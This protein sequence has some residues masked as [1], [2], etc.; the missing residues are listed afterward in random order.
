MVSITPVSLE[1][2]RVE[3]IAE[4][5]AIPNESAQTVK[6]VASVLPSRL[7]PKASS[8]NAS[9]A[10]RA[11]PRKTPPNNVAKARDAGFS[12]LARPLS[13]LSSTTWNFLGAMIPLA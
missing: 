7:P 4:A 13:S 6:T 9:D 10:D 3:A 11:E 1:R 2:L 5:M 8:R 12:S